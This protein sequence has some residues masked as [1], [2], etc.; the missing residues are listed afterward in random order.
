MAFQKLLIFVVFIYTATFFKELFI[1]KAMAK[2]IF[3]QS[4]T[5]NSGGEK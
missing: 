1:N 2:R 4:T 3:N 5:K